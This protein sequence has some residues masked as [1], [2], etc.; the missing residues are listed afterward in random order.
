MPNGAGSYPSISFNAGAAYT[1]NLN[2]NLVIDQAASTTFT[3]SNLLTVIA[4]SGGPSNFKGAVSN[5]LGREPK[6]RLAA[7]PKGVAADFFLG[8]DLLGAGA[9]SDVLATF[10]IFIVVVELIDRY[11]ERGNHVHAVRDDALEVT[12]GQGADR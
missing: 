12:V 6:T 1:V 11:D 10:V 5:T 7:T 3:N 2:L 4:G 8:S 9:A